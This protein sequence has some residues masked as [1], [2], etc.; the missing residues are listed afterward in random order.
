MGSDLAIGRMKYY[1]IAV[2]T[3]LTKKG[4]ITILSGAR[5]TCTKQRPDRKIEYHTGHD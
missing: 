2:A 4:E 5:D 1:T 3:C